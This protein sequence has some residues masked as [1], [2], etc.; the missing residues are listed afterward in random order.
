MSIFPNCRQGAPLA[1]YGGLEAPSVGSQY[2]IWGISMNIYYVYTTKSIRSN[3]VTRRQEKKQ[4]LL[5]PF[6]KCSGSKK[7]LY[8]WVYAGMCYLIEALATTYYVV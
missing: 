2:L 7:H 5:D 4:K 3:F 1:P 6:T 8:P